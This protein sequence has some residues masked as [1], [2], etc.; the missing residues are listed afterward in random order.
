MWYTS[1]PRV[2]T[3]TL[4][5]Q[6]KVRTPWTHSATSRSSG[7]ASLGARPSLEGGPS[8]RSHGRRLSKLRSDTMS[9]RASSVPAAESAGS[10]T[11]CCGSSAASAVPDALAACAID[12][13]STKA[14]RDSGSDSPRDFGRVKSATSFKSGS[15]SES[16][17][18]RMSSLPTSAR[19]RHCSSA[20]SAPPAVSSTESS[21]EKRTAAGGRAWP[22]ARVHE[23]LLSA[24]GQRHS[25][26]PPRGSAAARRSSEARAE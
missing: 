25:E 15:T 5:R 22:R 21:C 20:P 1:S 11:G 12:E 10:G 26:T 7:G 16:S 19:W 13:A 18:P 14:R 8:R 24:A 3:C 23:A 17:S 2:E 6:S 9:S 4:E